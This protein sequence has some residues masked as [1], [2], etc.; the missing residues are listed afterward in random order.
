MG[1]DRDLLVRTAVAVDLVGQAVLGRY[2]GL[3]DIIDHLAHLFVVIVGGV[4]DQEDFMDAGGQDEKILPQTVREVF[5]HL[6]IGHTGGAVDPGR[7]GQ[8]IEGGE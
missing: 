7:V 2:F 6:G 8:Y 1:N 4:C 5:D 3:V